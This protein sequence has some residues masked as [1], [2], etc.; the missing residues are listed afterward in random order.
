MED[1]SEETI[2]FE[3][4]D[5]I[6]IV[7]PTNDELHD[8]IFI[9]TYLDNEIIEIK[10]PQIND[11]FKIH[12][13]NGV[14]RDESIE[15]IEILDHPKKKGYARQNGLLP[16][17]YISVTFGG[18]IPTIINGEITN[19]E[20]DMI[21]ITT[22]GEKKV[23]YINFDYKGIPKIL[24]IVSIKQIKNPD[25]KV[26]T[27]PFE[28]V[29]ESIES[30]SKKQDSIVEEDSLKTQDSPEEGEIRE[31]DS[32]EEGEIREE[33]LLEEGKIRE[34]D[35][36]KEL[37]DDI[38]E[39]DEFIFM[40]DLDEIQEEVE[41]DIREK[42]FNIE[43]QKNDLLDSLLS[44]V[45]TY[46]RTSTMTNYFHK[47]IQRFMELRDMYSVKNKRGIIEGI[48]RVENKS[49]IMERIKDLKHNLR[50]IIPVI[51][52]KKHVYDFPDL[53]QDN[54]QDDVYEYKLSAFL[55]DF[56]E[57]NQTYKKNEVP[58]EQG[59]YD[60]LIR[61]IYKL[62]DSFEENDSKENIVISKHVETNYD[63]LVENLNDFNSHAVD[64]N[65]IKSTKFLS[66]RVNK[67]TTKI[68]LPDKYS[69][70]YELHPLTEP[71]K[72][73]VKGFLTFP[74]L[75][76]Y[77]KLFLHKT[78]IMEKSHI[79]SANIE[80]YKY[81]KQNLEIL[82]KNINVDN[83]PEEQTFDE[84]LFTKTSYNKFVSDLNFDDITEETYESFLNNIFPT[85]VDL[86]KKLKLD[87]HFGK[88]L[89]NKYSFED[90]L[91]F[92]ESFGIYEERV[93]Y[94]LYKEIA[95][96]VEFREMELKKHIQN[97]IRIY[98]NYVSKLSKL[99]SIRVFNYII[100]ETEMLEEI[101][102][103]ENIFSN[104]ENLEKMLN[105]DNTQL[106][107]FL[108]IKA[109]EDLISIDVDSIV[110]EV[111]DLQKE[112]GNCID[113]V[114][115]KKY[116]DVDEL[117]EDDEKVIYFDKKYDET[118]YDIIDEF[119]N[120]QTSMSEK[121]F[122]DFL[123]NHLKTNVGMTEI[124][125]K[126]EADA[127]L[128][129]KKIVID[130]D[131]AI[132]SE[133]L[134]NIKYYERVGNRWMINDNLDGEINEKSFCNLKNKCLSINNECKEESE[135]KRQVQENLNDEIRKHF[136]NNFD[137]YIDEIYG[138]IDVKIEKFK[139]R[140]KQL[141]RLEKKILL[142][143][144]TLYRKIASELEDSENLVSPLITLRD[145]ILSE[146]DFI[147]KNKNIIK[148]VEKFCRKN[149]PSKTEENIHW[150]YCL[151]TEL[152][153]L[154]T[155]YHELALVVVNDNDQLKNNYM[156]K[157]ETIAAVRGII[158]DDGDKIVDRYSGYVIKYIE[159]SNDEGYT[160]GGFR[161][162]SRDVIEEEKSILNISTTKDSNF[163]SPLVEQ[164]KKIIK[165]MNTNINITLKDSYVILII[166]N[167]GNYIKKIKTRN[168]Y[169]L[170]AQKLVTKGKTVK[171]FEKYYD[172]HLM[173][174]IMAYYSL[175]L[176]LSIPSITN[177][178]P[179]N[180]CLQSFSG[181]PIGDKSDLSL[182]TYIGCITL[183]LKNS[184]YRPWN[185]LPSRKKIDSFVNNMHVLLEKNAFDNDEIQQKIKDKQ[186][187]LLEEFEIEKE[188]EFDLS[189]WDTFL[190]ILNP[191]E[192]IKTTNIASTF[193]NSLISNINSG[194]Y[195]AFGKIFN[196]QQKIRNYSF[197]IQKS[198]R[199][200]IEKQE[201]LLHS[202]KDNGIIPYLQNSCC[203]TNDISAYA[204]FIGQDS[205][206]NSHNE[207]VKNMERIKH[208]VD[209]LSSGTRLISL[210]DTKL[211]Y[212][213][214]PNVFSEK[215]IY[216][217]F[218]THCLFNSGIILDDDVLELCGITE[219]NIEITN[220]L[221]ENI[222]ILKSEGKNYTETQFIQLMI[223]VNRKNMVKIEF[224]KN[225][226]SNKESF[227]LFF[228]EVKAKNIEKEIKEETKEEDEF[229]ELLDIFETY[230][231]HSNFMSDENKNNENFKLQQIMDE[232]ITQKLEILKEFFISHEIES[233]SRGK[234]NILNFLDN[235][236]NWKLVGEN[237]F[238]KRDDETGF[239]I[240][241]F[242][243]TMIKNILKVY[244]SIII[245][246]VDYNN[247]KSLKHW[248][249]TPQH[250]IDLEKNIEKELSSF[251]IF[252]GDKETKIVLNMIVKKSHYLL[253]LIENIPFLMNIQDKN[254]EN[255]DV[256]FYDGNI[257]K[258]LLYYI[259]LI[260]LS[261]YIQ[262]SN[263]IEYVDYDEEKLSLLGEDEVNEIKRS[264]I[265]IRNKKTGEILK[266]YLQIM[267]NYKQSII[268][269]SNDDI[270]YKILKAKEKEKEKMK[271][272]LKNL[273][274]E[275]RDV[276]NYL[277]NHRL[278][279]WNVGQTTALFRYDKN[280]YEE[281]MQEMMGDL[282]DELGV[283]I[284][285]E[286]TED[287]REIF[288]HRM[289]DYYDNYEQKEN[290][291]IQMGEDDD[292]GEN[293]GDE[294]F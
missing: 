18:D 195:D 257:Y 112:Q 261:F 273:T 156:R 88:I 230:N 291:I 218:L 205:T 85:D 34:E 283:G 155:F 13:L 274:K 212:P 91:D 128:L 9:I 2:S 183:K 225:I 58:D 42:R 248:E 8:K 256:S 41:V 50:W 78:N 162:S 264:Q 101:G 5:I 120:Q 104:S 277:K 224:E 288:G 223:L 243:K 20:D 110:E 103:G 116:I 57:I 214:I 29:E 197:L 232:K 113:F 21:E 240:G 269:F 26:S 4:G 169:E 173:V 131:Y 220:T 165:T 215:T 22:Y 228:D 210:E 15:V 49:S 234:K 31:E 168:Q 83:E 172:N 11:T 177:T 108:I 193:E 187:Y 219:S 48:K 75:I 233:N 23:L 284:M 124:K 289:Q 184:V 73:E 267:I 126:R 179:F 186:L 161:I 141:I 237:K 146:G 95:L 143:N 89:K 25:V 118:R 213:S 279:N 226:F 56:L 100:N 260:C 196:L 181:Y 61:N 38:Q 258:S 145:N 235:F 236:L 275:E 245:N 129:G 87:K 59:K 16:G 114:L 203:S 190:P 211:K 74:Q 159:S 272:R 154:P 3:L 65:K 107:N 180:G 125:A 82:N 39:G 280:R 97:D 45:P 285:D 231:N 239:K 80:R 294:L 166:K 150:F 208:D 262:I 139:K 293:D 164:I 229:T 255:N 182:L 170:D 69:K 86:F 135:N 111:Q 54:N 92:L 137:D 109:N 200:V 40:E 102:Y 37:D 270:N 117:A 282:N 115:A 93:V 12:L 24:P 47:I 152:P 106:L 64:G 249:L 176:Q 140:L 204:Y 121:D 192:E 10:N 17:K 185:A 286:T 199:N 6:R 90:I 71:H 188:T 96:F 253:N 163:E 44:T 191:Y 67:G 122:L 130:G 266:A 206:I 123:I 84:E 175:T 51:K 194:S 99:Q 30:V 19:L 153:L 27:S 142:K 238:L 52:H 178:K 33:D 72:I 94:K 254:V 133:D 14:I 167:V 221:E 259:F 244:P 207:L 290:E 189:R 160:E 268:N 144:N 263:S 28:R 62:M 209:L 281:E 43:E 63:V 241:R 60:Y 151:S 251:N 158:S 70:N 138:N 148:F 147:K 292:F 242:L 202:Y 53:E 36:E 217:G 1:I 119:E 55:S 276:E 271:T 287:Q 132:L 32:L 157:I 77:S 222:E 98:N 247:K 127:L 46:E 66:E 35:V 216:N 265:N 227:G 252:T 198:I 201:L 278:G 79:N 76:G 149:N 171:T 136:D 105:L 134:V 246:N 68:I 81:L 250:S 174:A 7:S